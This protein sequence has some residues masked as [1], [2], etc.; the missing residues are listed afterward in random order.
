MKQMNKIINQGFTLIELVIVI[1]VLGV[2]ATTAVP[3]FINIQDDAKAASLHAVSGALNSA[4]NLVHYRSQ[5]DGVETLDRSTIKINGE[6]VK[7]FYAYPEASPETI[8]KIMS[9]EGFEVRF[10]K[11]I[12]TTIINLEGSNNTGDACITYQQAGLNTSFTILEGKLIP[13]GECISVT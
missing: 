4:A 10:G 2:I 12:G 9:L 13:T 6:D 1:I 3:K 5:L 11:Y 7:L 8:N